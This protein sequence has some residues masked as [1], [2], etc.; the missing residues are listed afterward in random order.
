MRTRTHT[1]THTHTTTAATINHHTN[2]DGGGNTAVDN[3]DDEGNTGNYNHTMMCGGLCR[4]SGPPAWQP[5][6]AKVVCVRAAPPCAGRARGS[7]GLRTWGGGEGVPSCRCRRGSVEPT[8]V[9][10]VCV[11]GMCCV[12]W[13]WAHDRTQT[14]TMLMACIVRPHGACP[15]T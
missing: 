12:L 3:N 8:D 2:D 5:S 6:C 4:L 14:G 10:R 15:Q 11:G 7:L 1:D 9:G 13:W